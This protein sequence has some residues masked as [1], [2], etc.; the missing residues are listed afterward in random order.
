MVT[1]RPV[2]ERIRMLAVSRLG[3]ALVAFALLAPF[4]PAG[5]VEEHAGHRCTCRH[6]PER[7]CTCGTCRRAAA[8][9]RL[10]EAEKLPPCH[11]AAALAA[12]ARESPK[13]EDRAL[14]GPC[15]TGT[16]GAPE[17]HRAV[18]AGVEPFTLPRPEALE[19]PRLAGPVPAAAEVAR[20]DLPRSP[21]RQPPRAS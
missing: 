6:G 9:A 5:T 12:A 13:S 10:A 18:I 14:P 2:L 11:R 21:P 19:A 20:R 3:G 8:R 15:L 1:M 16:C 4:L 7:A 17:Q